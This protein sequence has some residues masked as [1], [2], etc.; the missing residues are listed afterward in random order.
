MAVHRFDEALARDVTGLITG[1]DLD[2]QS[3]RQALGE[4]ER[5]R[6]VLRAIENVA[7]RAAECCAEAMTV[8]STPPE[9]GGI[10]LLR[11]TTSEEMNPVTETAIK[12]DTE[13]PEIHSDFVHLMGTSQQS[14]VAVKVDGWYRLYA[15]L[16]FASATVGVRP[17]FRFRV[18]GG[19]SLPCEGR[20][21]RIGAVNGRASATVTELVELTA[22]DFV[23]VTTQQDEAAGSATLVAGKNVFTMERVLR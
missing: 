9:R 2:I 4:D 11:T 8:A 20:H 3:V 17:V 5:F 14:K 10:I 22:D 1:D 23:E 21:G 16:S 12:W 13:E 18:N 19:A 15:H 7:C 6:S